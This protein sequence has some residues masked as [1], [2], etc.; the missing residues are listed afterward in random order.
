MSIQIST[1]L[2]TKLYLPG[3]HCNIYTTLYLHSL[4]RHSIAE[5][6]GMGPRS[7]N[8]PGPHPF[9]QDLPERPGFTMHSWR[10]GG[11]P[12]EVALSQ[13][14]PNPD[15]G[16]AE[17]SRSRSTRRGQLNAMDSRQSVST[18][19]QYQ[20]LDRRTRQS[21]FSTSA[22][23]AGAE[24]RPGTDAGARGRP[25]QNTSVG[26]RSGP[27]LGSLGR[28]GQS[29][30]VRGRP[31]QNAPQTSSG[32]SYYKQ[33]AL[34]VDQRDPVLVEVEQN[35]G[36]TIAK[37]LYKPGM[38]V[39]AILHEPHFDATPTVVDRNRTQ[40]IFGP[41]HSKYRKMIII[42]LYEDH[43]IAMSV[44]SCPEVLG[45]KDADS[46]PDPCTRTKA[47]VLQ[48]RANPT[49]MSLSGITDPKFH[50]LLS[51]HITRWRQKCSIQA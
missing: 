34:P 25:S 42:A 45:I 2:S 41:I 3:I 24:G 6:A 48:E 26:G 20:C 51:P 27:N 37:A 35:K 30:G 22:P 31:G 18:S 43:Y 11:R 40:S 44:P 10:L 47:T 50:I 36:R 15:D 16:F 38:I 5:T 23:S 29:V 14:A 7:G 33:S 12:T 9:N 28:P 1:I 17:V 19:P 39:R 32:F 46:F 13:A 8:N 21:Q 4:A 49:N